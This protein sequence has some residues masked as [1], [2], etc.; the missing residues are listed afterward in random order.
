MNERELFLTVLG[1]DDSAARKT[2]LQSQRVGPRVV[3]RYSR[4]AL[5][6]AALILI[7]GLGAA[8]AGEEIAPGDGN[9]ANAKS[10]VA[11]APKAATIETPADAIIP[12]DADEAAAHQQAWA[13]HLGV[14]AEYTN[15]I[16]MKFVL[17]PPGEFLMGS[18]PE[19][20]A[21]ALQLANNDHWRQCV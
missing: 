3:T 15:S 19:E 10:A 8:I 13:K 1:I 18:T 17:I 7:A 11:Q 21:P 4:R 2:P 20:I 16:G 9:A 6:A 14:P 12:F 5:A